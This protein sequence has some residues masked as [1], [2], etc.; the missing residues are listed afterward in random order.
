[1]SASIAEFDADIVVDAG[2]CIL[3][4]VASQV[5]QRALDG[6]RVAIVNAE[7]AVITGDKE[8]IFGTYRKRLQLG[9]DRGPYYPKRPDTIFKRSVRGML[10]YKKPRGREAL[11]NV[12]VYVGNPYEDDDDREAEILEDTSLDRLSNIRF[13]HLGEVSDQLGANVTW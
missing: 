13:V 1:M 10:P 11:D 12:R 6:E 2:D 3:G 7:D 5:A 4:R 8:D 9:S